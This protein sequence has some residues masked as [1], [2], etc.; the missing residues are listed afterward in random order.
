[1]KKLLLNLVF[2]FF[3]FTVMAQ[4]AFLTT[5]QTTSNSESITIPTASGETYD[6]TV[7]WGDGTIDTNVTGNITHTYTT[8]GTYQV[9]ITGTFPR[10][11]FGTDYSSN[12]DKIL[13]VDQ[14]GTIA[15]SSME[16][17]FARCDNV[18]ISA[19]DAP[20]LSNV[21]SL[22][23]M[24]FV[25]DNLA[26]NFNHWNTSNI[27]NMQQVFW[28]A[29]NFNEDISNWDTSN[30][31]TMRYMFESAEK[32]NQDISS[33][34][35]SQV[36]DMSWM[37]GGALA[38]NQDISNWN[39]GAVTTM[40]YMF[41]RAASFNQDIGN[42]DVSNVLNMAQMFRQATAFDQDLGKWDISKLV[43]EEDEGLYRIFEGVSLSP[44]NYD[45]ILNGWSTLDV[46]AGET[47]IP[48]GIDF[49][50]PSAQYCSGYIGRKRLVEDYGWDITDN[51]N[52]CTNDFISIW[53][54]T[55][56]NESITIPTTGGGYNYSIDWGDGTSDSGI[57]GDATQ[58]YAQPGSHVIRIS[59]NFPRIYFNDTGDKD[60]I[61]TI[62]QW[63]NIAWSSFEN[64]F[65]GC[66]NLSLAAE[67]VANTTV[68]T[69]L[70]YAFEGIQEANGFLSLWDI[71]AVTDM[72]GMF[73][74]T[75]LPTSAY[76][77][78]LNSWLAQNPQSN[79]TFSAG[80][81]SQYCLGETARQNLLTTYNWSITDSNTANCS[82]SF[83]TTWQT[84]TANEN[85]TIPTEGGGYNYSVD[86]GDGTVEPGFTGD[87]THTYVTAGT[88]QVKITGAFPRIYMY[89][90]YG[91]AQKIYSIDQW[92]TNEWTS[93]R[94]AFDDCN[95]LVI[96]ASDIPNLSKVTDMSEM[97]NGAD[98]VNTELENW[99]VS[100]VIN[101]ESMFRF[102]FGFNGDI[103]SWDVSNV[104]NMESMFRRA[105][106][107][108]QNIGGWNTA[109]L[110]EMDRMF[111]GAS[112]FNQDL[113]GWNISKVTSLQYVFED[114][115]AFNGDISGW[116]VSN[117]DDMD[118]LFE[119]ATS[120]NQDLGA[121]DISKLEHTWRTFDN[122]TLSTANYD[123]ILIGWSTLDV[124][125]G[126]TKIPENL[127][128]S[129]GSSK[130]CAG[131]TARNTLDTTYNWTIGDGGVESVN[132]W[133]QDLDGDG[134]G[135]PTNTLSQC[136]QPAGYV[137][138][139]TD[140]FVATWRNNSP[141][142][143]ITIP[144]TGSG[145]NYNVDWGDGSKDV[146]ITG[147]VTHSYTA[148][149]DYQV[150]ITGDFPRFYA[151]AA[152]SPT[153]N[154][155]RLFSVDQWGTQQWVSMASAFANCFFL[156][157]KATD[158]PD[159][160]LVT[161]MSRMFEATSINTGIENW[162]VS[163]VTNME[164]LFQNNS[165]FNGDI[166]GWNTGNVTNMSSMFRNLSDFN[167]DIG[168]WNVAK[169]THMD[170]MFQEASDFDQD[171]GNWD[172]SSITSMFSLLSDSGFS[173]ENYDKLLI[174][175]ATL[176]TAKGETAI[177]TSTGTIVLSVDATYCEGETARNEL[178]TTYG[179]TIYD[180]GKGAE[181]TWY[182]DADGD[183]F[184][185]TTLETCSANPGT[186]Y[187]LSVL[188]VTDCDDSD[189]AINTPT[190]WYLDADGDNYAAS[191]IT[192]CSNPGTGYTDT[193]L[194]IT[195]CDDSDATLNP[196]T[197]WYLDA[198]GDTY[199]ISTT[200]SCTN[201][202]AGYTTTVLPLTDCDD[203]NDTVNTE[204][205]WYLDGDGDGYAAS[206]V[207]SCGSPG[208]DYTDL[209]L[210]ISDCDDSNPAIN[211]GVS[212]IPNNGFDDDCD[213]ATLDIPDNDGDGIA[214]VDDLYP[215]TPS[216]SQVDANGG[217][218]L[219]AN[220]FTLV[221]TT[222]TC[223]N[224]TN[225]SITMTNGSGYSFQVAVAGANFNQNHVLPGNGIMALTD[226]P[227]GIYNLT[228]SFAEGASM[229]YTVVL[230]NAPTINGI[231]ITEDPFTKTV[232]YQVSGDT[233]YAIYVNNELQQQLTFPDY[234]VNEVTVSLTNL[235]SKVR[236]VAKNECR[237][238]FEDVV[239]LANGIKMWPNPII[240]TVHL[241]GFNSEF[242]TVTIFD[243]AGSLLYHKEHTAKDGSVNL[244]LS[245]LPAG[246]YF[247]N[248][249]G[250][251]D[252]IQ[253]KIVK[254]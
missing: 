110:Q 250:H 207:L 100:K 129:F 163:T 52:A 152:S 114:A 214:N 65:K 126:E 128:I 210:P 209:V 220:T 229:N 45:A 34:D 96:N 248:V 196:E 232:R 78:I 80:A 30:V 192:A 240:D 166:S 46:T 91:N 122:A 176:D 165:G 202:G 149:G 115:T 60:K 180:F 175:W 86:W 83:I 49:D 84:T 62:V 113:N 19:T 204:T 51:G 10:I 14:W 142:Q 179:W 159:L 23:A 226:V 9:S 108:N 67:D 223:P 104:T 187:T 97:F 57:T 61:T 59:G 190:T 195:D 70:N 58:T 154:D 50:A 217:V 228:L 221:G 68:V 105:T 54:T 87:A 3:A 112:A 137:S 134:F 44:I 72:Q 85:I 73:D 56:N 12:P 147:D 28:A 234:G 145:Y 188:P 170:R 167:R 99:D 40:E 13:S 151:E 90:S 140:A 185:T 5:W 118:S 173:S 245:Y 48:T 194:P 27:T 189:P 53:Q 242:V 88:Y 116:D 89:S 153:E 133:Y 155:Q 212:E 26:G 243:M 8:A 201:P 63:G 205:S 244:N 42:W 252:K 33:W 197:V 131:E 117:V 98:L 144:T 178:M 169:V 227:S 135:D 29:E 150:A 109:S 235:K 148:A 206:S 95:N 254:K 24:F 241:E 66:S 125:A 213:P 15:W 219:D 35:V 225:G 94:R 239:Y 174:G 41:V 181:Q 168:D 1:M 199:A 37:F 7:D 119:D 233:S 249:N 93:M 215:N 208:T 231:K 32:F 237:G 77:Q 55:T 31:T 253:T 171:L 247:L 218:I 69:N 224:I 4:D 143:S 18:V 211:P 2:L 177:P 106:I 17:A 20:D 16:L 39:T 92:G 71:T 74:G 158:V 101:M 138:I 81:L 21:T 130:Y 127:N 82:N 200:I 230:D 120:F 191:S 75:T 36:T 25:A 183:G 123:S 184:A 161:D 6:Y 141:G 47:V 251:L 160:S 38:F 238:S 162:N 103:S 146:G 136:S 216:G 139:R 124:A 182:L 203:T 22:Y 157:V 43:A 172:I 107:F 222:P 164:G 236:I 246:T 102:A 198:D 132:V 121:W 193:V 111:D 79:V 186:G 64:A 76:D 11:L 156:E